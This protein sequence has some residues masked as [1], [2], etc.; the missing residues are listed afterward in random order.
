MTQDL[1]VLSD[2]EAECRIVR[3]L[4]LNVRDL[5]GTFASREE[6]LKWLPRYSWVHFAYHGLN[7]DNSPFESA[8]VVCEG[9]VT[10]HDIMTTRLAKWLCRTRFLIILRRR[11][12]QFI[13]FG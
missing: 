5:L 7:H 8:F 11:D 13:S 9:A 1:P 6:L 10:L 2:V 4:V 12:S 3:E